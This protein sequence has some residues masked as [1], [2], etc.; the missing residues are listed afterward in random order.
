M[1]KYLII[2]STGL[3]LASCG[4]Y[5]E[6]QGKA[7]KEFCSCMEE[8]AHGDFDIDFFECDM[9]V[10]QNYSGETFADEGW[11]EALDATCPEISG[12]ISDGD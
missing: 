12:K 1:K 8:G 4:G 3:I 7:A 10:N 5:S 6:E 9:K 2:L 11:S